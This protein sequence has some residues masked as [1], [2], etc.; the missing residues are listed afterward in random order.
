MSEFSNA[1][2]S[3]AANRYNSQCILDIETALDELKYVN[4]DCLNSLKKIDAL[5]NIKTP[6]DI[7]SDLLK[8]INDHKILSKILTILENSNNTEKSNNTPKKDQL[9]KTP[10]SPAISNSSDT[11]NDNDRKHHKVQSMNLLKDISNNL[12]SLKKPIAPVKP[13]L[14]KN[15][16]DSWMS[17]AF[18]KVTV[19]SNDYD[20]GSD[21]DD[22]DAPTPKISEVKKPGVNSSVN[23]NNDTINRPVVA[24]TV[25]TT[26]MVNKNNDVVVK[27]TLSV[28]ERMQLLEQSQNN[29]DSNNTKTSQ[30]TANKPVI[31]VTEQTSTVNKNNDITIKPTLSVKERMKLLERS[32]NNIDS[33]NTKKSQAT[34][35]KPVIQVTESTSTVNQN[36]ST[37]NKLVVANTVETTS[38]VNKNNDI[39]VKSTLSVK[40]RMKLLEQSQ[41]NI[42]NSG[43]AKQE[44][45]IESTTIVSAI[46]PDTP[47]VTTAATGAAPVLTPAVNN[48]LT[49]VNVNSTTTINITNIT[50]IENTANENLSTSV[51]PSTTEPKPI[52]NTETEI[53]HGAT[54]VDVNE[55][56]ETITSNTNVKS[57]SSDAISKDS[58]VI[59]KIFVFCTVIGCIFGVTALAI[60][61]YIA[62]PK[63]W[64]EAVKYLNL[65]KST[66]TI[67]AGISMDTALRTIGKSNHVES[68]TKRAI[69]IDNA[70]RSL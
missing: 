17:T 43:T 11:N 59:S 12:T 8:S 34:A 30:A 23:T 29:I 63:I 38:I 33:N 32:Q 50:N 66:S 60:G 16:S 26:S 69:S 36:S 37:T 27:P 58:K 22:W 64:P 13:A 62:L 52:I 18:D 40:E 1:P 28:K 57:K 49:V 55:Q 46:T 41:N 39:T 5:K 14:S 21:S 25:E 3:I 19:E 9:Q 48:L 68:L 45:K 31:Q 4:S 61:L 2:I 15:D 51:T 56:P 65:L 35:N 54:T 70:V 67:S 53:V 44:K 6:D 42:D 24:N 7:N 20:S 10:P 47:N